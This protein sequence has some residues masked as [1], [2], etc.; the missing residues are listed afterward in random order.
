MDYNQTLRLDP[1]FPEAY[2]NRGN[3]Y[4]QLGIHS[5][6]IA[7]YT[8]YISLDPFDAEIYYKRS[9]AYKKIDALENAAADKKKA[10]LLG[11]VK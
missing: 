7:D 1:T 8:H 5:L 6:A 9:L 2:F 11:Y 10:R 3:A 4:Y